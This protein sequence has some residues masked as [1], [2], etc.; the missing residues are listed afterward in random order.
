MAKKKKKEVTHKEK[1]PL[2]RESFFKTLQKVTKPVPKPPVQE[3]SKTS[4]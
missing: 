2:T 4:E 3:K 1:P